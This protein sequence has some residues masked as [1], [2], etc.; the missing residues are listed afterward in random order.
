MPRKKVT[1]AEDQEEDVVEVW[2]FRKIAVGVVIVALLIGGGIIGKRIL[3]HESLDPQSFIPPLPSVKSLTSVLGN[4]DN[5]PHVKI[6]LP[7]SADI[8][9]QVQNIQQEVTHL[10]VNEIATASPQ[11]RQVLKQ[12]QDLPAGPAGQVKEACIRLCSQL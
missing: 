1:F 7:S 2:D 11:V 12:L 5:N 10:N 9:N 4:N 3:F 8:Q 6:R